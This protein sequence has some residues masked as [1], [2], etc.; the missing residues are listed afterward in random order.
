MVKFKYSSIIDAPVEVVWIHERSN[1]LALTPPWLTVQVVRDK[2]GIEVGAI[3][4]FQIIV[5]TISLNWAVVCTECE[6]HHFFVEQQHEGPFASWQ[7]RHLF[8]SK[9]HKTLLT[10]DVDFS[11]PGGL[12]SDLLASWLVMMQLDP[13]FRNRH[14][15][16]QR[17]CKMRSA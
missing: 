15:T 14:E 12:F 1:I 10:D 2:P 17:E 5:G 7:H 11:L 9:N 16:I 6:E 8:T 3:S 13:I 4:E